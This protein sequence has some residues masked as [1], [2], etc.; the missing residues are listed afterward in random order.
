VDLPRQQWRPHWVRS[1]KDF[2]LIERKGAKFAAAWRV[3][4]MPDGPVLF[5][6]RPHRP[7]AEKVA[8]LSIP[9]RDYVAC[10]FFPESYLDQVQALSR[11]VRMAGVQ[12][13]S[14]KCAFSHGR[15]YFPASDFFSLQIVH[16]HHPAPG[17]PGYAKKQ[18]PIPAG[19][20][21]MERS[22][23][24]DLTGIGRDVSREHEL[25]NEPSAVWSSDLLHSDPCNSIRG[26][27]EY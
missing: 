9:N 23:L 13:K 10:R 21:A 2:Y 11:S 25:L 5:P 7:P 17:Q 14:G 8:Y 4:D 26:E 1:G 18:C 6:L 27:V 20:A 24:I 12:G 15:R 3:M 22:R 16:A 19:K